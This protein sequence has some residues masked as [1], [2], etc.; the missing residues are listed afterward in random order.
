V[1]A[2]FGNT[3]KGRTGD[4][5]HTAAAGHGHDGP[6]SEQVWPHQASAE[7]ISA[8]QVDAGQADESSLPR[9]SPGM[10]GAR[11]V[12]AEPAGADPDTLQKVLDGL[13]RM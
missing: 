12:R 8:Q 1:R 9:R 13:N 11:D 5:D 3:R 2:P 4:D 6:V 7:V 10:N